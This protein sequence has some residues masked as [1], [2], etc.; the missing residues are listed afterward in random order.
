MTTSANSRARRRWLITAALGLTLIIGVSIT[1]G[2]MNRRKARA[3]LATPPQ[4][5]LT[6]PVG[7]PDDPYTVPSF[8]EAMAYIHLCRKRPLSDAELDRVMELI[9]RTKH[10]LTAITAMAVLTSVDVRDRR[11]RVTALFCDC[12]KSDNELI[13]TNA[14]ASLGNM[15]AAD[16]A[17]L[18]VPFLNSRHQKERDAARIALEKL[19]FKVPKPK[20]DLD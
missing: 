13:R 12:L 6:Q 20:P 5:D 11:E 17:P 18:I 8:Q 14:I 1:I 16:K 19:G 15:K 10:P 7:D 9:A 3:A 2:V 4:A